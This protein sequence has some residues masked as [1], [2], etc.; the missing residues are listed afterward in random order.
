MYIAAGFAAVGGHYATTIAGVELLDARP[1]A[2]S[3]AGFCVGA[4]IKYVLNYFLAFRSAEKHSAALAKFAVAL[5]VLF[6]LNAL[7]FWVLQSGLG[8]HYIVAQVL[9]TGALILPG[10]FLSRLWVF[11]AERRAAQA[12]C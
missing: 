12:R 7:V 2:A 3:A 9:T 11:A 6:A 8:L 10:Y 4:V 5:A 1:L